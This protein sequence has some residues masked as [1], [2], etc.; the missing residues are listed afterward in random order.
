MSVL[1]SP[2]LPLAAAAAVSASKRQGSGIVSSALLLYTL[3]AIWRWWVKLTVFVNGVCYKEAFVPERKRHAPAAGTRESNAASRRQTRLHNEEAKATKEGFLTPPGSDDEAEGSGAPGGPAGRPE[4]APFWPS[5]PF[6]A[7]RSDAPPGAPAPSAT[8][9]CAPYWLECDGAM[10]DVRNIRYKQ[11]KEKVP[12]DTALYDCVGMDIIRDKRRIDCLVDRLPCE[13]PASHA[14]AKEWSPTWGIPRVCI[15][16]CQLPYQSGRFI[17]AHPEEDGG[18]SV[19]SYFVLSREQCELLSNNQETP[20][21]RLLRRFTEEGVST[22]TGISF[23]V[24]GRVEDMDRY[25]VPQSFRQFNNKP[26]LLTATATVS[27]HRLPEV[28]EIDY[29]VRQ[30][31]YPA[32]TALVNYHHRAREAE[33]EIAYLVEG[34]TDDELPEQ[35]LGCFT[36]VDMDI[37]AA[38]WVSVM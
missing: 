4:W 24:V 21:L 31:V 35:I 29:D 9:E 13:L 30:W 27:T 16:N 15:V 14:K 32:R 10:F 37:M 23:K 33:L 3:R 18:L 2:L 20:S 8:A 22:K 34:K 1:R 11:T 25:E 6:G 12:S 5:L 36:L 7:P 17:G 38:R 28:L 26:V 19:L